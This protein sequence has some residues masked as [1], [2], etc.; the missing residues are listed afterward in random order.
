M[1]QVAR[2]TPAR[3][4]LLVLGLMAFAGLVIAFTRRQV[5]RGRWA[6]VDA[7]GVDERR[8]LNRFLLAALMVGALLAWLTHAG[9]DVIAALALSA[10]MVVA[11][12]LTSPVCKLSLHVAFAVFAALLVATQSWWA[13]ALL[14]AFAVVIAWSRSALGRHVPRDLVAGALAGLVAGAVFVFVAPTWQA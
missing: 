9:V 3:L 11:A 13:G 5:R 7:S 12:M 10:A 14:I 6:H 1:L 2:A 8:R 4:A